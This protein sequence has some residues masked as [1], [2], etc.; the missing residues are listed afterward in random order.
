MSKQ[1]DQNY[2]GNGAVYHAL[3]AL[4]LL[5]MALHPVK[6][7]DGVVTRITLAAILA[8]CIWA[9][10]R[11]RRLLAAALLLGVPAIALVF[12]VSGPAG[13]VGPALAIAM[14]VFICIVFLSRI[15]GHPVVTAGTI[16]ASLVVYLLLGVIWY[17]AYSLLERVSPGSF[18]GVAASDGVA[19][20][21]ELYYFSFVTL[22]TLGYGD[23]GPLS[24]HAR[25]LAIGEAVIGQL[26]LVVLVASL[27]GMYLA[28]RQ[29]QQGPE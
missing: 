19:T 18:Y 8:A 25:S 11:E 14:L 5:L 27:V 17:L 9:V 2:W 7:G 23:I 15:A 29:P 12:P 3:L 6:A 10:A 21:P 13:I 1:T 20:S 26:Y 16:S 4:L 22:T 24:D 28:G